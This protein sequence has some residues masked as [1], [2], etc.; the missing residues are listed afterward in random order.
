MARREFAIRL[1]DGTLRRCVDTA[2]LRRRQR[3]LHVRAR[4]GPVGRHE[5]RSSLARGAEMADEL[6]ERAYVLVTM[7][8]A[9]RRMRRT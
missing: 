3:K 8:V 1:R 5:V 2:S 7:T 4:R 9:A 6:V